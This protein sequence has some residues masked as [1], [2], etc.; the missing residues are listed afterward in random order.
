MVEQAR[1]VLPVR[2]DAWTLMDMNGPESDLGETVELILEFREGAAD[3][4]ADDAAEVVTVDAYAQEY[5]GADP[6][7][8][9]RMT[10]DTVLHGDGW[11]ARWAAPRPVLGYVRITGRFHRESLGRHETLIVPTRGAL[12]RVR[13]VAG[14]GQVGDVDRIWRPDHDEAIASFLVDLD[15]D[16][17]S[18]LGPVPRDRPTAL[19]GFAV[20]G[21]AD[22]RMLWRGDVRLPVVWRTDLRTGSTTPV[23]LPV[24]IGDAGRYLIRVQGAVRGVTAGQDAVRVLAAGV[25]GPMS[26]AF[27]VSGDGTF[28]E[29]EHPAWRG[30]VGQAVRAPRRSDGE[31]ADWIISRYERLGERMHMPPGA[32]YGWPVEHGVQHLGRVD[33]DGAVTWLREWE[34]GESDRAGTL[35]CAGG[36]VMLWRGGV[37]EYLDAAPGGELDVVREVSVAEALPGELVEKLRYARPTVSGRFLVAAGE[38]VLIVVDPADLSVLLQVEVDSRAHAQVDDAATVWVMDSRLRPGAGDRLRLF[39]QDAAGEWSGREVGV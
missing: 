3:D 5:P 29:E 34:V 21:E 30:G 9:G 6:V 8:P 13:S 31:G 18:R 37:V 32:L 11:C 7:N 33:A 16:A 19:H 26:R 38:G 10:W 4:A 36:H 24:W 23:A 22:A 27:T 25:D 39:T 1:R 28:S 15:L 14:D 12:D 20:T 17:A 35:L 2:V